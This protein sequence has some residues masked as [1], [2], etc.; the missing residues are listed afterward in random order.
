MGPTVLTW[1]FHVWLEAT[2][3]RGDERLY[4]S[5]PLLKPGRYTPG[6]CRSVCCFEFLSSVSLPFLAFLKP[7]TPPVAVG[8]LVTYFQVWPRGFRLPGRPPLPYPPRSLMPPG[9]VRS[10]PA[11]VAFYASFWVVIS[12]TSFNLG[13]TAPAQGGLFV[14]LNRDP[15]LRR[16]S[17]VS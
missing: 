4:C 11:C 5:S 12:I 15:R 16:P 9:L 17:R 13:P 14:F 2:A 1:N 3:P 6:R 10:T 7:K 8:V